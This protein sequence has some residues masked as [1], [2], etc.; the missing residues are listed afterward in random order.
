MFSSLDDPGSGL[1]LSWITRST[2]FTPAWGPKTN[3]SG[4]F[5]D[6]TTTIHTL[7]VRADIQLTSA[8]RLD[9]G[10]LFEDYDSDRWPWRNDFGES[11][12]TWYDVLTYG[13]DSPVYRTQVVMISGRYQF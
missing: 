12:D 7:S 6:L 3:V 5:P 10:Y 11:G 13:Y 9:V 8:W 2:V 4:P 1:K